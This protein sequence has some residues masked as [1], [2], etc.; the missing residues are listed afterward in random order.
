MSGAGAVAGAG[1]APAS[2][3]LAHRRDIEG[4]RAVAAL[5]V[6]VYHIWLGRVS[7]GV[8][9]FFVIA[10]FLITGTLVRQLHRTGRIDPVRY[11]GRLAIRLLPQA[12]TVLI[13]V[14][15][16]TVLV[17]PVT[18]RADVFVRSSP[19]PSTSRTGN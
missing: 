19:R 6:A 8:D 17:F 1:A 18:R 7:G 11:L 14:G 16:A 13:A 4:L 5:L 15:V 9:V 2:S 12:L 3:R 10:G